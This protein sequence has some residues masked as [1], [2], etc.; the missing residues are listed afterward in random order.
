MTAE[1]GQKPGP[2]CKIKKSPSDTILKPDEGDM[3]RK[4]GMY[5]NPSYVH[6]W[7]HKFT[8]EEEASCTTVR[9]SSDLYL[10]LK[11]PWWLMNTK[12]TKCVHNITILS[13]SHTS[14]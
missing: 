2:F 3:P 1:K 11:R 9:E 14:V 6:T 13:H 4:T 12:V 5:D 7:R 8:W 10:G